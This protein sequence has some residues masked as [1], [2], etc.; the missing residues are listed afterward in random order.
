M[1]VGCALDEGLA[2][3][4]ASIPVFY[5]ERSPWWVVVKTQGPTGHGSRFI[6][7]SAPE[8]LSRL[9][10]KMMSFRSSQAAYLEAHEHE[11]CKLGH[12]TSLNLTALR[13][14]VPAGENKFQLNVIPTEAEAGFD[15][16]ITPK[17][18][19]EFQ[20]KFDAWLAEEGATFETMARGDTSLL[21]GVDNHNPWWSAFKEATDSLG[22]KMEPDIFSAN[23]DSRYLRAKGI[24][25]FGVS[26]MPNT[27]VLLHDHNERIGVETFLAAIPYFSTLITA[28]ANMS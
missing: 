15:I 25:A 23:T 24:P 1:N 22:L 2:S 28:M 14:G 4:T 21:T 26:F 11:G 12:V 27:T 16:R 7:D 3:P 8:R 5:G 17:E 13:A 10:T 19:P 20:R 9:V 6:K 18:L